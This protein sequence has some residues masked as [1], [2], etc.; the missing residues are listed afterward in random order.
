MPGMVFS[1][2]HLIF[3]TVLKTITIFFSEDEAEVWSVK[4]LLIVKLLSGKVRLSQ[5]ARDQR[6]GAP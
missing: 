3:R 5:A 4:H 2:Y 1:E 6:G